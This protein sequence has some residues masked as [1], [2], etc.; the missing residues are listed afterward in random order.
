MPKTNHT[1]PKLPTIHPTLKAALGSLDVQIEEELARYRKQRKV[2]PV[3]SASRIGQK[4]TPLPLEVVQLD[5]PPQGTPLEL[6][7]EETAAKALPESI[8]TEAKLLSRSASSQNSQFTSKAQDGEIPPENYLESSEQLLKS[9]TESG[10]QGTAESAGDGEDETEVATLADHLLTPLGVGSMLL[11]LL[12]SA[13]LGYLLLNPA[14]AQ[15]LGLNRLF[16]GVAPSVVQT[17]PNSLA[18]TNPDPRPSSPVLSPNLADNELD[19]L[20]RNRIAD[21]KPSENPQP[22]PIATTSPSPAATTP[23]RANPAIISGVPDLAGQLGIPPVATPLATPP[24][25]I[26][27]ASPSPATSS[28]PSPSPAASPSNRRRDTYFYVTAPY[29]NDQALT[30]ARTIIPEAYL[31]EVPGQGT[32]IQLGAF[33]VENEAKALVQELSQKGIKANIYQP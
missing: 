4:P 9:L 29:E 2:Q 3:M 27:S 18:T 11:L 26:F 24:S 32:R 31:A 8:V 23:N 5:F 28:V 1:S 13:S 15:R 14:I 7:L 21:L 16:P 30:Q 12:S 10:Q 33:L 6:P 22:S 17:S 25:P 19:S 20:D